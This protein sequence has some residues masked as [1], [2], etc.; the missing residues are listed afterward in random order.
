LITAH[1]LTNDRGP[2]DAIGQHHRGNSDTDGRGD[3][4]GRPID[5]GGLTHGWSLGSGIDSRLDWYEEQTHG[6]TS[7]EHQCSNP[8]EVNTGI[9]LRCGTSHGEGEYRPQQD[10]APWANPFV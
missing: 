4:S 10:E 2:G 8:P 6:E 1:T 3:L 7:N 5:G 9:D